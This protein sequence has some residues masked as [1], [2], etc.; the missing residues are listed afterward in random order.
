MSLQ[1]ESA[2]GL[3]GPVQCSARAEEEEKENTLTRIVPHW[4]QGQGTCQNGSGWFS[5]AAIKVGIRVPDS[6][7]GQQK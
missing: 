2:P 3:M 7:L 6:Q 1:V 4:K 5:I